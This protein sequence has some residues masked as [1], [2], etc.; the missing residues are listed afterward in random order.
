MA[1][2]FV[3]KDSGV[4]E[5]YPSG[6]RR[7]T[8]EGKPDYTLIDIDFLTR[9]A[10][11]LGKGAIKYGEDNWR[12]ANSESEYKRFK[13]SAWRHLMQWLKGKVDEDHASAVVFNIMAAEYVKE[14]I[15]T[16]KKEDAKIFTV[17]WN[18]GAM[19]YM[20][21]K[22]LNYIVDPIKSQID[23]VIPGR[24]PRY[25]NKNNRWIKEG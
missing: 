23:F 25:S 7:D 4:R 14:K 15:K 21:Q 13:K 12:L 24:H 18:S 5:D 10:E 8:Q 11:H 2:D 22:E 6:M 3:V 1:N 9:F 19:T 16:E 20:D 17:F